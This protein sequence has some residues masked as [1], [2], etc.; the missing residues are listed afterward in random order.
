[1]LLIR[2]TYLHEI[3]KLS[4]KIPFFVL[5]QKS[6]MNEIFAER[7]KSARL[8]NGFSLQT[9][10][11][12]L[13]NKVSRQALHR[14]EKGEVIPDSEMIGLLCHVLNVRPDFFFRDTKVEIGL[15]EYRKLKR[16]PA[17]EESKVIEQTKEYLGR[18]LELEEILGIPVQFV[19]PL[20]HFHNVSTYEAINEAANDLRQKWQ[21][22]TDPIFNV[23]ELLEDKHIKVVKLN[24]DLTFDGL[25]TW[26]N[27]NIPVVAYNFNKIVKNDRVR[28]TLLHELAH[29][30]LSFGDIS[31]K[32]KEALC[33]QFAGAML[34]PDSAIKEEL[35]NNRNRLFI[36]ELGNIKK[37]YGISMQAIVMRAKACN[38]INDNYTKQFFFMMSQ[39]NWKIDE[40]IEYVGV[41][42]S[43]RFD[44]LIYRALA[45]ELISMS[46]AAAL[47]NQKL[48]EFR[49]KTLMV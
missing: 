8:L 22:G 18:Y 10:A 13:D 41:E 42:Q 38:I 36:P 16:M 17:K 9:L 7:F 6:T 24:A 35:G 3:V 20:A 23:V 32:Q 44:Q 15:V 45:E 5:I 26:V 4:T 37:Q 1:M 33:H 21:L 29:L 27:G 48:A 11:D 40:P 31:E 14:Y 19:N 39:N 30:L 47:K 43:N 46:K 25:Q 12:A 28:F 49:E 34:L 2:F